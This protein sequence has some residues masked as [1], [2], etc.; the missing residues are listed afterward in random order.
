[1]FDEDNQY[2][3]NYRCAYYGCKTKKMEK[4]RQNALEMDQEAQEENAPNAE[5]KGRRTLR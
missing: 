4:E 1:M 3:L 5:A 2:Q